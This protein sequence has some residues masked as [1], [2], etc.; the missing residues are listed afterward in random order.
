MD[1]WYV[2]NWNLW[3]DIVILIKTIRAVIKREGAC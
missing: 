3:L 1:C 2:K